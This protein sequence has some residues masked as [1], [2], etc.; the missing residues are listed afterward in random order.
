MQEAEGE[1]CETCVFYDPPSMICSR[2]NGVCGSKADACA[3]YEAR[4]SVAPSG[5]AVVELLLE[6]S[7]EGHALLFLRP[8]GAA[9]FAAGLVP[10]DAMRSD[11]ERKANVTAALIVDL[12]R[13][14]AEA[15]IGRGGQ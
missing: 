5:P 13:V 15:L 1:K 8:H 12:A 11:D 9:R 10:S 14:I 4:A 2:M 6:T 7:G 3:E